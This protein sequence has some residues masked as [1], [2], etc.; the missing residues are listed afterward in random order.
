M[1]KKFPKLLFIQTLVH[2]NPGFFFHVWVVDLKG[3]LPPL[4]TT[5]CTYFA[6]FPQCLGKLGMNI[7]YVCNRSRGFQDLS[8]PL[9]TLGSWLWD[10]GILPRLAGGCCCCWL[11]RHAA[12]GVVGVCSCDDLWEPN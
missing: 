3:I 6:D 7:L 4:L 11:P 5:F 12:G 10:L 8:T 9:M 2:Y 1:S